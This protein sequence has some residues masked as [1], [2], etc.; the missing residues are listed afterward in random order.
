MRPTVLITALLL[1]LVDPAVLALRVQSTSA[2]NYK[3]ASSTTEEG[4]STP[5]ITSFTEVTH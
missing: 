4:T 3:L 5:Q 2:E 1:S